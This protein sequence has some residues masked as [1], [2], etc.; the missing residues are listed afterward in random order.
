MRQEFLRPDLLL[1]VF[2]GPAR[3]Y[4]AN[5]VAAIDGPRA[6]LIDPGDPGQAA[7]VRDELAARG[8]A[9][10][11]ILLTHGHRDHAGG[12]AVFP[13][14][15]VICREKTV[16]LAESHG[17][18]QTPPADGVL[19]WGAVTM[20]LFDTPG[21]IG[22]HQIAMIDDLC[23]C[24]DLIIFSG[25]GRPVLPNVDKCGD[26]ALHAASLRR[27]LE[28]LPSRVL[29]YHGPIM[30]AGPDLEADVA[31]R[32]RYLDRLAELGPGAKLSDCLVDDG[33][34]THLH[35]HRLNGGRGG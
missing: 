6:L 10:A 18:V 31:A 26:P 17:P 4:G 32:L 1:Y 33:Y 22:V 5:V 16:I 27:M 8:V 35:M 19:V 20:L 2:D 15:P 29:P 14:I 12:C 13:D 30:A 24:G 28:L 21:H 3:G 11:S 9:V 23:L 25:D 34:F 7:A